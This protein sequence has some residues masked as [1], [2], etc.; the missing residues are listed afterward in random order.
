MTSIAD[1]VKAMNALKKQAN[2]L[3]VSIENAPQDTLHLTETGLGACKV[4]GKWVLVFLKFNP[5]T[6][7][8]IV[9]EI[10][11]DEDGKSGVANRFKIEAALN[12]PIF[13]EE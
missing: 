13:D 9:S 8:A 4:N 1:K 3:G 5:E 11:H 6:K 7:E 12:L 10:R 2:E